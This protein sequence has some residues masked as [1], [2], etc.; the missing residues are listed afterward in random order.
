M[1]EHHWSPV[2]DRPESLQSARRLDPRGVDGPT[3][4]E[5]RG[6]RWERIAPG[7]YVPRDRPDCVEQRILEQS[8]RLPATLSLIHI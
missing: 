1:P 6:R 2:C 7:L 3:P 5:A 4:G 8:A